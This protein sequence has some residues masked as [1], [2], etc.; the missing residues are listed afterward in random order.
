MLFLLADFGGYGWLVAIGVILLVIVI[1]TLLKLWPVK[2]IA[3]IVGFAIICRISAP[4]S[5]FLQKKTPEQCK[6]DAEHAIKELHDIFKP[7]NEKKNEDTSALLRTNQQT[8]NVDIIAPTTTPSINMGYNIGS[9][10]IEGYYVMA[11]AVN[12]NYINDFRCGSGYSLCGFN[13]KYIVLRNNVSKYLEIYTP[14]GS[15]I[16]TIDPGDGV[17]TGV[18]PSYIVVQK[19]YRTEYYNFHGDIVN[20]T[21]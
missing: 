9:V 13:S 8:R 16:E 20:S 15:L 17:I 21:N 4:K 10:N 6:A 3:A 14:N 19:G 1:G 18:T 11:Y 12:G 2:T 5:F 7:V